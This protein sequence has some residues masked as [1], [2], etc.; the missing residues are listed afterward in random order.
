[1]TKEIM[2]SDDS[3]FESIKKINKFGSEFWFARELSDVLEYSKWSNFV[4]V[5]EKAKVACNNSGNEVVDHFA[6]VG[7]MIKLPKG[8]KRE[9]ED[10]ALSRYACYLIIQEADSRKEVVALGKTYFAIQTRKQEMQ[11][12]FEQLTEEQKRLAIRK[13]LAEHNKHLADAAKDAGVEA[14]RDYAIFQNYGYMG[15]YGG[16]TAKDIHAKKGLK[17]SH[18]ILDYMGSTE[19]AANLFRATQ[20]EEILRKENIRGKD[21]ANKTHREVGRKVRKAIEDIGGSMPED[22]PTPTKSVK[23]IEKETQKRLEEDNK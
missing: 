18:K 14:G 5:I 22:L 17:K 9:V 12:K 10:Y 11:E 1:M 2:N 3:V 4:R 21:N 16:M 20:T 15:L 8:A 7:K 6:D 13:D 23:K 19:L